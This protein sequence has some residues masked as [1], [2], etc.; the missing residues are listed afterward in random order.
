MGTPAALSDTIKL[1]ACWQ[2]LW[3]QRR[4]D[5]DLMATQYT[6]TGFQ[7]AGWITPY[8]LTVLYRLTAFCLQSI[9]APPFPH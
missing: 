1:I 8:P 2:Q 5:K 9:T 3:V 6:S 7:E 4:L